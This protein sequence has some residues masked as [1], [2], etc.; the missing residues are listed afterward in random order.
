ME[1]ASRNKKNWYYIAKFRKLYCTLSP[2]VKKQFKMLFR[3][4]NGGK[5][6]S[7]RYQIPIQRI[8]ILNNYESKLEWK[9]GT[10]DNKIFNF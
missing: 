1:F 9:N 10:L 7:Q 8:Q 3:V 5:E 6:P 2:E 4:D